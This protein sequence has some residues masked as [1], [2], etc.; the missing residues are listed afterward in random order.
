M[1]V[2]TRIFCVARFHQD[3]CDVCEHVRFT[4]K[5]QSRIGDQEVACPRWK[6]LDDKL[7]HKKPSYVHMRREICLTKAP[8]P[9]QDA[10][11]PPVNEEGWYERRAAA[12]GTVYK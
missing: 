8:C 4:L 5:F 3:V 10:K 7:D 12:H 9:N 11:N 2:R 6:S 1:R